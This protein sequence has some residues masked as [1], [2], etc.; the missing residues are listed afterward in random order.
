MQVSP[1]KKISDEPQHIGI[2]VGE[3][4]ATN[5][6]KK[7]SEERREEYQNML[8]KVEQIFRLRIR[9]FYKSK[10]SIANRFLC[11]V[12]FLYIRSLNCKNSEFIH[13]DC[14]YL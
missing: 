8:K 10:R 14:T 1:S 5:I 9:I 6:E 11:P 13:I 2:A 7:L 4:D 12:Y 3:R